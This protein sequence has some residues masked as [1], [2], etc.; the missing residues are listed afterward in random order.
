[1]FK[2]RSRK[3]IKDVRARRG[4]SALIIIAITIGVF[5]VATL[6]GL[7]DIL[8]SQLEGDL[9][10]DAIAMTKVYVALPEG[11]VSAEENSAYLEKLAA[12][13]GVEHVEGQAVYPVS[14]RQTDADDFSDSNLISFT[15][16]FGEVDLEPVSRVIEGRY[17]APNVGEIAIERRFAD[18]YGLDVGDSMVFRQ[19]GAEEAEQPWEI[20]GIVFHPYYVMSPAI[21]EEIVAEENIYA[22]YTD[23]QQITGF[24]GL[25]SIMARY[26]KVE[27]ARDENDRFMQAL[28][29]ETPYVPVWSYFDDPDDYFLIEQVT[30]TTDVLDMLAIVAILVSGFLVANV[31]NTIVLEQK[32][33]IGIMKSLGANRWDSLFIYIGMALFYGIVGTLFGILLA[34]PAAATLAQS[35]APQAKTYIE[36][37]EVSSR[38]ILIGAILGLLVPVLSSLIPVYNGTRIS[39]L[40]AITDLGISFNWGKSRFSRW[41]GRLPLPITVRQALSN[42]AQKKSRL[43]LTVFTLTLAVSAFMGVTAVFGSLMDTM[44]DMFATFNFDA[45]FTPQTAQ[46]FTRVQSLIMEN[47]EEAENVYAGYSTSV[48]LEGYESGDPLTEGSSQIE[49]FGIDPASP[50]IQFDLEEGTGW[51]DDATREGVVLTRALADK[52]G[53]DAGDM[54]HVTISGQEYEYKIIGVDSYPNDLLYFRWQELASLAGFVDANGT[55]LPGTFYVDLRGEPD[56]AEVDTVIEDI[57]QLMLAEDIQGTFSNQPEYEEGQLEQVSLISVIFNITSALMALIGAVGLLTT[58]SMAVVERQKE[59]GVMRSIGAG[60]TTIVAQFL[61]EGVLV[62]F[63]AWLAAIPLSVGLGYLLYGAMAGDSAFVFHYPP[64]V[65]LLGLVGVLVIAAA[66]SIYPSMSAARRTVSDILRYK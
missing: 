23:A 42:I 39:V 14:W 46:D 45:T 15:E 47:I 26:D 20:V 37:F 19:P 12:L 53:K 33:Q 60:S 49:A 55:P 11:Q 34:L 44:D 43:A 16:P 52:L 24:P 17:P 22:N 58:L 61:V 66:A 3:I 50:V 18:K 63:I 31:I 29:E 6:V 41:I 40:D 1:M 64:D 48:E 7:T 65:V 21:N 35:L 57:R 2:T 5:G 38:G 56:V 9:D 51:E 32:Q 30:L 54:V 8:I 62:G 59:I 28:N 27:T 25:S 36:G 13:P 4:R 10:K